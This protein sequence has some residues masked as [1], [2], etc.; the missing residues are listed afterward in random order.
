ME[1]IE[2]IIAFK[3][4]A[5]QSLWITECCSDLTDSDKWQLFILLVKGGIRRF[6]SLRFYVIYYKI[7]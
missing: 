6:K 4:E 5:V 2:T 7:C 3:P 1:N